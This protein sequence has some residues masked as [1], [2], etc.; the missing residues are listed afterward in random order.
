[1]KRKENHHLQAGLTLIELLVVLLILGLIAGVAGPQVMKYVGKSKVDTTKIQLKEFIPVI[2]M[3][4]LDVGR[5]PSS[6]EGLQALVAAPGSAGAAWKG[7]YLKTSTIPK[8]PWG[9]EYIY[10]APGK[11]GEFDI[12]SLGAD[13]KEGGDGE[14]QDIGSWEAN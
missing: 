5:V 11:H 14:N 7:P 1:M 2:E 9:N 3:Y 4:K 12:I 13:G 10:V 6:Q 8:D